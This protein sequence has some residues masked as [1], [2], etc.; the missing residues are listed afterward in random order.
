MSRPDYNYGIIH[1][2][3]IG[4]F[5]VGR[6]FGVLRSRGETN[7]RFEAK[8]GFSKRFYRTQGR[9]DVFSSLATWVF[10]TT[11]AYSAVELIFVH[12][13]FQR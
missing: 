6:Q 12:I 8:S 1:C 4:G 7:P 13:W 3:S 10:L 11:V 9:L 2:S 5:A